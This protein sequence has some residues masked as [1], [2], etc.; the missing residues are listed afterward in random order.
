MDE[1]MVNDAPASSTGSARTPSIAC[2]WIGVCGFLQ[3]ALWVRIM[4]VRIPQPKEAHYLHNLAASKDVMNLC[5]TRAHGNYTEHAPIFAVMM[6]VVDACGVI[7]NSVI[8]ISGFV[9]VVGRFMHAIGVNTSEGSTIGRMFGAVLTLLSLVNLM[10]QCLVS[11]Y[12]L[13][14]ATNVYLYRLVALIVA[15]FLSKLISGKSVSPTIE[16]CS[17]TNYSNN[18]GEKQSLLN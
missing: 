2:F 11:A 13:S 14:S 12:V 5:A 15:L 10:I 8:E 17:S 4:M 1:Y 9:F 7:P 6:L 3:V 18:E 16:A